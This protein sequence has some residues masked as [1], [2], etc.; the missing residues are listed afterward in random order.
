MFPEDEARFGI[1]DQYY[2]GSSG[3]L[4]K[5]VTEKGVKEVY[6]YI[7]EDQAYYNFAKF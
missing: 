5:P 4:V 2:G 6:V 1:D 3:L 7:A